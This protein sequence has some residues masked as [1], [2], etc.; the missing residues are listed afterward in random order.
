MRA[1]YGA[2]YSVLGQS[3]T[4]NKIKELEANIKEYKRILKDP[5][6]RKSIYRAEVEALKKVK[7]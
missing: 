1:D 5:E 3:L 2:V 7:F 4:K 6:E